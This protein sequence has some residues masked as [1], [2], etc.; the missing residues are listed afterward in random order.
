MSCIFIYLLK[1]LVFRQTDSCSKEYMYYVG[2]VVLQSSLHV[3][4]IL[5]SGSLLQSLV[6][7]GFIKVE[8]LTSWLDMLTG[9]GL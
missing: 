8:T 2:Y 9:A 6:M 1:Y 5:D 4:P 3:G 7:R